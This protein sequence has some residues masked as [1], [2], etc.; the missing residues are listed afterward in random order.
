MKRRRFI[1]GLGGTAAIWPLA[2]HGQQTAMPVVGFLNSVSPGPFT[3]LVAAFREGLNDVG[4]VEGRNVAIEYRWAE[5]RYDRLPALAAD[6]VNRQVAVIVATGGGP[7]ALAAKAATATIPIVFIGGADP[8]KSG[9]VDSLNRPGGNATG[10]Q[11][12]LIGLEPKRLELL[13]E[14]AP[15]AAMIAVLINP[16]NPDAATQSRDVEGAAR[17][18]GQQVQI[19]HAS[20]EREIDT[21]FATLV[22]Q[23]AG[24][25]LV[26]GDPF[27]NSRREQL[28]ALAELHRIPANYELREF[29]VAGGLMSYGHSLA[30]AYRQVGVYAGRILKGAKPVDLPVVRPTNFE[31]VINLRAAKAIGI[32][33]PPTLLA[34][35]DEVIE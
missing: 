27:F 12:F 25:V 30:E 33:I 4:Y 15:T 31:L 7:S 17:A 11:L 23:R 13:R 21:A 28:T 35:A 5:G 19:L 32:A 34:R 2:A 10:L 20:T 29:A 1:A 16:N 8:V 6:L 9:L 3:H 18:V 14:L 26:A 22:Q 24:A